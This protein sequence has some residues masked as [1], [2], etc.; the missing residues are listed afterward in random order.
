MG[1]LAGRVA[2]VTGASRGLGKAIAVA[3]AAEGA[4]VAVVARTEQQWDQR[5]PGTIGETVAEIERQG[6]RAVPIRADLL[7]REDRSRLIE[8]ARHALGP[9]TVLV[10]NAAFTAPG[11]PPRPESGPPPTGSAPRSAARPDAGS[12]GNTT[13]GR[14]PKADWPG[15]VSTP[16]GAYERHFLIGPFATYELMQRVVPDM[17]AA[18]YG[19][20]INVTSGASRMPGE[21][22]YPDRT[23]GILA[24]YGGSKAALEHLTMSA[25][26]ELVENNIAVNA[27]S[28]SKA[29]YT[30]GV[31]Y[32]SREFED[33]APAE[34][35]AEAA[36]RLATAD[37]QVLTGRVLGHLDVLDGS[38]RPYMR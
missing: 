4:A 6:G 15:F 7:Q 26:Y 30:P 31:A 34:D 13:A 24:G 22:P 28:P 36:V 33:L 2:V 10:N 37:P 35:F 32:Y 16:V 29:I 19:S 25:A 14:A 23:E 1:R 3:M 12:R 17:A 20:I 8:E 18:G 21:G 11:R 5:L 9:I 27:L 38:F